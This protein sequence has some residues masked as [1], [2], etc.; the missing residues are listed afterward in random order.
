MYYISIFMGCLGL[1]N[2]NPCFWKAGLSKVFLL[3]SVSMESQ[4]DSPACAVR[5]SN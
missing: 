1:E 4:F 5:V 3:V 2:K